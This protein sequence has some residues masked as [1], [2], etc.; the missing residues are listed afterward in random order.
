MF[1]DK[2]KILSEK[3]VEKQKFESLYESLMADN[4]PITK[5]KFMEDFR[6]LPHNVILENIQ[7]L[8]DLPGIGTKFLKHVYESTVMGLDQYESHRDRLSYHLNISALT[9]NKPHY[10]ELLEVNTVLESKIDQYNDRSFSTEDLKM[11]VAIKRFK[12]A[13]LF[14]SYISSNFD[15]ITSNINYEPRV[16]VD[17]EQELRKLKMCTDPTDIVE[18]PDILQKI[19][20]MVLGVKVKFTNEAL[21]LISTSPEVITSCLIKHQPNSIQLKSFVKVLKGQIRLMYTHMTTNAGEFEYNLFK[22]YLASLKKSKD[23]VE[24]TLKTHSNK[25]VTENIATMQPDIIIA[26]GVIEDI[27]LEV[28]DELCTLIDKMGEELELEDLNGL[29]DLRER[30]EK[31]IETMPLTE[32]DTVTKIAGAAGRAGQKAVTVARKAQDKG[33]KL[34][35]AVNKIADP[36]VNMINST[37]NKIKEVD[38]EERRK[39]IVSGE[40]RF[41]L[42]NVLSKS[43][44]TIVGG[45]LLHAAVMSGG[46]SALTKAFLGS[47]VSPIITL[48]AVIAAIAI[49]KKLDKKERQKILYELESELKIVSEKLDDAKGDNSREEKYQLMRIQQKLQHDVD[50]IKY[51]L[52]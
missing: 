29:T 18:Y 46:K 49:D 43:I 33:R 42:F 37:I 7:C 25:T 4:K 52:K 36:F 20:H 47:M 45:K 24:S 30:L 16:L 32:A 50:R 11:K 10:D 2:N 17:F 5:I 34:A 14:E 38:G 6:H 1:I 22:G 26:D 19:T 8:Y 39:R 21:T 23:M 3:Q 48:I 31:I 51:H 15:V 41:K 9:M 35:T 13:S 28:D 27:S 44:G 12:E 40:F